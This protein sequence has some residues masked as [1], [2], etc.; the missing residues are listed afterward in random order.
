MDD[1]KAFWNAEPLPQQP[2]LT[3]ELMRQTW[4]NMSRQAD[5]PD[6]PIIVNFERYKRSLSHDIG[7]NR[8]C[9]RCDKY[10]MEILFMKDGEKCRLGR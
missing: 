3:P 1:Q 9:R 6:P 8:V 5:H 7:P 4:E 2:V 10:L